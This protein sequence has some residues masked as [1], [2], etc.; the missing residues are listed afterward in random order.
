MQH[1]PPQMLTISEAVSAS[2]IGRTSLY[3]LIRDGKLDARK[4]GSRTLIPSSALE[5]LLG[6]LPPA[7]KQLAT[8]QRG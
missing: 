1:T 7:R 6:E 5:R 4:L 8:K 3:G 2:R